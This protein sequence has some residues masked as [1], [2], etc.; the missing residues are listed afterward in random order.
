MLYTSNS[1]GTG[2]SFQLIYTITPKPDQIAGSYYGRIAFVLI[3]VDSSESQ[4]VVTMNI[5]GELTA[6]AMGA[7]AIGTPSGQRRISIKSEKMGFGK[8]DASANT[9]QVGFQISSPF[10]ARYRIYQ[11]CEGHGVVSDKG[12][13][14]DLNLVGVGVSGG[15]QGLAAQVPSLQES[16]SKQL[17]YTSDNNGSPDQFIVS[18]A[19]GKEFRL[20]KPGFY[21]GRLS[22]LLE[23]ENSRGVI[24]TKVLDTYDL[25]LEI[26]PLFDINVTTDGVEGINLRFGEVSYKSGPKESGVDIEVVSNLGERYQVVQ[27]VYSPM[28]NESGDRVPPDDFTVTADYLGAKEVP[29]KEGEMVVFD[30]GPQGASSRVTLTYRLTMRPDSKGG[31]YSAQL[32]YSLVQL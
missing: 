15:N 16:L 10:G 1:A 29:A 21:R 27:K 13:G 30:S 24:E 2:D 9:S 12:D 5:Y 8:E 6:G 14:F 7:V 3:P 22:Y 11:K 17:L 32:G 4:V 18:Y 28:M 31:R 20:Q 26:A 23:T 19:P 25:A